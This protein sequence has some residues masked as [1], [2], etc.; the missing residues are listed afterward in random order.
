[1]E[2]FLAL[3]CDLTEPQREA[4]RAAGWRPLLV[5]ARG[6]GQG[7]GLRIAPPGHGPADWRVVRTVAEVRAA[8]DEGERL[9]LRGL[10][11]GGHVGDATVLVLIR[12]AVATGRPWVA[13]GL[14]VRGAAA[15]LAL[16]AAGWVVDGLAW[17]APDLTLPPALKARLAAARG[18]R[19]TR[20]V[21]ELAGHRVRVLA[22]RPTT[23]ASLDARPDGLG[24]GL[25]ADDG[26]LPAPACVGLAPDGPLLER[27]A[28]LEAQVRARRATARTQH[29][30]RTDPLGTGRAV[31][32]GPMANVA[33][34]P[35]LAAAVAAA[36]GLPFLAFG[37]LRP[38]DAA[39]CLADLG[40]HPCGVGVMGFEMLPHRDAHLALLAGSGR[41]VIL[42]GAG[43]AL[44]ERVA[45]EGCEPWLHTP[46]PSLVARALD[47]GLPAVVLEGHEAGGHVGPLTSTVLW[48]SALERLEAHPH[49]PL[50]V[51]AGGIGD[52]ASAA[53]AGAMAAQ[54]HAGGCRVAL[55]AGTAFFFT[56]EIVESRQ[57]P[58]AYQEAALAA[59]TTELVGASVDLPLRCVPSPFTAHARALEAAWKAEG[60]PRGERRERLERSN[61]GRTR[62]AARAIERDPE[63]P[64]AYREV[65]P[66]RQRAEG[67]FTV[68]QGAAVTQAL[69]SVQQV[70]DALSCEAAALLEGARRPRAVRAVAVGP[71]ATPLA[72]RPSRATRGRDPRIAVVGAGC[73]LPDAPDVA[74]FWRRLLAGHDAVRAL[75]A[76]RWAEGRYVGDAVDQSVTWA[77][78]AVR[79]LGFDPLAFRIPPRTVPAMD[80]A[81]QLALL[82][83]REAATSA[84]WLHGGVDPRRAAVILGNSM[85]GEH[86]KSLAVRIRHREVL[87]AVAADALT[88]GWHPAELDALQARVAARL[89]ERLPPVD[90]E[91]M[92]GLLGNVVA[93][94]VAAWLDWMGGNLTVDAAC[95]ASLGAVTLAVDWLRAGRVDAVLTGGVDADLSPETYVGFCR[96]HALS[97]RGAST[98]FAADADGFVMGEGAAVLALMRLDD[99][100]ARGVP[101]WAVIDGVG[102]ASDGRGRGITA[103][104]SEG[105]RLAIARAWADA[106]ARAEDF[107][108]IEAHGTGTA[109]GDGTEA[110][111]LARQLGRVPTPVWLG[112]VKSNLGHLKGAAGAAGL[113]R[114]VLS[115]LTGVA[116]PTLHAGPVRDDAPLQ[117]APLALPRQPAPLHR[118]R[119]GVSAFGFGGTDFHAVLSPPPEGAPRPEGFATAVGPAAVVW[120]PDDRV[121]LVL[122]FGAADEAGLH[123][124]V[125]AD[126]PV[127][128][129]SAAD[130]AWRCVVLVGPEGREA[131]VARAAH[132]L[133]V[134]GDQEAL[135]HEVFVGHG[136]PR[137][138]VGLFPGQGSQAPGGLDRARAFAEGRAALGALPAPRGTGLDAWEQRA[139]DDA[140]AIHLAL[141]AAELAWA[142]TL[143]AHVPVTAWSGHSLGAFA[144]LAVAGWFDDATGLALVEAR[145]AAL[146]ACPPGGMLA[147]RG[148]REAT[149]AFASTHG[150]A[151]AAHNAPGAWAI[152]G[153]T[154]AIEAAAAARPD[155]VR[156]PV[157]RA[158]HS[159]WVA[160]AVD[161][162][163]DVLLR[164][165]WQEGASVWSTRSARRLEADGFVEDLARAI[166][167]PVRFVDTVSALQATHRPLFVECGPGDVLTRLV[168]R[169]GADAVDLDGRSPHGPAR[170]AARLWAAGHA[171]LLLG[172]PGTLGRRGLAA[173]PDRAWPRPL[174]AAP[175][176]ERP[177]AVEVPQ[178]SAPV[179]EAPGFDEGDP[180]RA[181]VVAAVCEVTGY[182]AAFLRPDA[183]LAEELGIDSIRK[184]EVLGHIE[185]TLGIRALESDYAAL[186]DADVDALVA[187]ARSRPSAERLDRPSAP[188]VD[189]VVFAVPDGIDGSGEPPEL[190]A[191]WAARHGFEPLAPALAEGAARS[192]ARAA[193]HD[194]T[195]SMRAVAPLDAG[196]RPQVV[197]A[198]GGASGITAR[199]LEALAPARLLLLGRRP[200][201]DTSRLEAAGLEVVYA[202]ADLTDPVAVARA[203]E[204]LPEAWGPVDL[205][206]HGAGTLRDGPLAEASDDDVDAVLGPKLLG[207]RHLSQALGEVPVWID[208][209]SVVA[210]VGNAA[211]ALYG[212][213]N[214]ALADL[215]VATRRR[216]TVA[217][218]AWSEVGMA[219]DPA[220]LRLLAS[221]GV[222]ALAP[223]VGARAFA[224]LVA[225]DLDGVV[226]VWREPPPATVHAPAPLDRRH[227]HRRWSMAL[228]PSDPALADHVVAGRPLVPAALWVAAFLAAATDGSDA[229]WALDDLAVLVPTFVAEPRRAT[230]ALGSDRGRGRPAEIRVDG[231]VVA[232]AT[233]TPAGATPTCAASTTPLDDA[234]GLYRPDL[235]FH[236]PCWQVLAATHTDP[237]HAD[238][239]LRPANGAPRPAEVIDG[240][241]QL[242][243]AWGQAEQG[244]LGLPVGA[245]RWAQHAALPDGAIRITALPHLEGDDIVASVRVHAPSGDVV[246]TGEGV[247]LRRAREVR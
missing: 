228:D 87:D 85:G 202:R 88:H 187:W 18:P 220:L 141:Y 241:H 83:A 222:H 197:V 72:S 6:L 73:V 93:G 230:V 204:H 198:T 110:R 194:P 14:G 84:G 163:R 123:A 193:G 101:V 216:L 157:P 173:P 227:G 181:A 185:Q 48:E 56:H 217:W 169:M 82:A 234:S 94:R 115:A 60:H 139:T 199:C 196:Y 9:W 24:P 136:P 189:A 57:I 142:R 63:R 155:A 224:E 109:L 102:Q 207:A 121:P 113:L 27:L 5:D 235:L 29:P 195:P 213:A 64:G 117:G 51:L 50:V 10:E 151:V 129:D 211:Q 171:G 59:S 15:A 30:L 236:G 32:Q 150:L 174:G 111:A 19:A 78:G 8:A 210:Y 149:E 183:D 242:L 231:A 152:A 96:T 133:T 143:A 53:F 218:T 238:A 172:L 167:D 244:W 237:G 99:A 40:D 11:S 38:D 170:A 28:T 47:A 166:A 79:D 97:P 127:A 191:R 36:G 124:V 125:A 75:P 156:V 90:V 184:M 140:L 23:L 69:G 188:A 177:L 25:P 41:P 3:P 95:A 80:R 138:V 229:A 132:W 61:L 13:E 137:P 42:A 49:K 7:E 126:R 179:V 128:P 144:A 119:V 107:G 192:R 134:R 209:S 45:A 122:A 158:Y 118:P 106:D 26:P 180:V 68:G 147:L 114:G 91:S 120:R 247:R 62:I 190:L 208:F 221:R 4:V 245:A 46:D 164:S 200:D 89:A 135:G 232:R 108:A 81:Q 31:V 168:G 55:Q 1:M 16:G 233:L 153:P 17:S 105:Q 70:V 43:V 165:P 103:P 240:I 246:L 203:V 44:A 37:A 162:L 145:G 215:P 176:A 39:R 214:L 223:D 201:A 219:A 146:Q 22:D 206:V 154:A 20:L 67:A 98:P 34:R 161:A 159:P 92:A 21:G 243:C 74:T 104:R 52:A 35:G 178:P 77:A 2:R 131:T 160:P 205:V 226:T 71:R 175:D 100:L 239:R 65:P 148:D 212:A 66:D 225:S 130:H 182:P 76:E 186:A 54:A 58:L 112:S 12:A 116:P 86:A 33:E